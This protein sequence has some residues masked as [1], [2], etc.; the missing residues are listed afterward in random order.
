MERSFE[1]ERE[2]EVLN[3]RYARPRHRHTTATPMKMAPLTRYSG[4]Q[5]ASDQ[6][7]DRTEATR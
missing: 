7:D 1:S 5:F 3:W 4:T 6:G 2:E